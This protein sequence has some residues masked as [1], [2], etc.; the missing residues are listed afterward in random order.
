[1]QFRSETRLIMSE[2]RLILCENEEKKIIISIQENH[3]NVNKTIFSE[4]FNNFENIIWK[5]ESIEVISK[6][7]P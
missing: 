4:L 6:W 5:Y 2:T 7:R 3:L 1:M